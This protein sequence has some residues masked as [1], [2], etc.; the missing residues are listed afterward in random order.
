MTL[1]RAEGDNP[2]PIQNRLPKYCVSAVRETIDPLNPEAPKII[3]FNAR[4]RV[5]KQGDSGTEL[6]V[7]LDGRLLRLLAWKLFLGI[8][9]EKEQ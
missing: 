1:V 5:I 7:L 6:Y 4:D 2:R 8:P 3:R 9:K